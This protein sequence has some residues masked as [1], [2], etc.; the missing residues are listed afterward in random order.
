VIVAVV[1]VVIVVVALFT[2]PVSHSYSKQFTYPGAGEAGTATIDPPV[3][4]QVSGTFSTNNGAVEFSFTIQG[5]NGEGDVYSSQSTSGSFSFTA[6]NPPYTFVAVSLSA[7]SVN[8]SG[9][10]SVPILT[11]P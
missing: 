5:S 3:R 4:S 2:V 8:V 1:I 10:Y 7:G 9:T 11:V 6:S